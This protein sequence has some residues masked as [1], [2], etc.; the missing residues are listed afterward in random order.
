[1]AVRGKNTSGNAGTSD[2]YYWDDMTVKEV[3]GNVGVMVNFDGSDF[4]GDTP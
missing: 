2:F 3:T 1:M 4:S